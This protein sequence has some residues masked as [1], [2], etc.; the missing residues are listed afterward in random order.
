MAW[1][2]GRPR[3]REASLLRLTMI[4]AAAF[5]TGCVL[6]PEKTFEEVYGTMAEGRPISETLDRVG[7]PLWQ[8]SSDHNTQL[9]A[10]AY[11]RSHPERCII[12]WEVANGIIIAM[13]HSGNACKIWH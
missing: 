6:R 2:H 1:R 11:P 10:Y 8:V 9:Y 3:G 7:A 4:V 5:L 13:T 12:V